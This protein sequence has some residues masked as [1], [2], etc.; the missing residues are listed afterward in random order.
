MLG[1]DIDFLDWAT[2]LY[3]CLS[4]QQFLSQYVHTRR[5]I[6]RLDGENIPNICTDLMDPGST[7]HANVPCPFREC[8]RSSL[9]SRSESPDVYFAEL[10]PACLLLLFTLR[11]SYGA[12][13]TMHA[14]RFAT[15]STN[16]HCGCGTAFFIYPFY[17]ATIANCKHSTRANPRMSSAAQIWNSAC[18]SRIRSLVECAH[19][20]QHCFVNRSM[21][22]RYR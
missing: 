17:S 5:W 2:F 1:I 15:G 12:R 4:S 20:L 11:S 7:R 18:L 14:S 13:R 19:Y 9:R 21:T 16:A 6:P 8:L 22:N 10:G 3:A